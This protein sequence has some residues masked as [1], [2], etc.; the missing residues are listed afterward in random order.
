MLSAH[1]RMQGAKSASAPRP[2]FTTLAGGMQEMVDALA[3]RLPDTSL[4]LCTRVNS[5]ELQQRQWRVRTEDDQQSF[6]ALI[7]ALPA[8]SAGRLLS[9]VDAE[10]GPFPGSRSL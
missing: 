9:P 1:K 4:R 7:M 6:D 5:V 3:E 10:L 2:L 8:S